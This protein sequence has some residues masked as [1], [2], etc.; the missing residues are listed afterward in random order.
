MIHKECLEIEPELLIE[1]ELQLQA[2]MM[3]ILLML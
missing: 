2:I 1:L 3:N